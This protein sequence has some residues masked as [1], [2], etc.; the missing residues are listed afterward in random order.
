VRKLSVLP[1]QANRA[2]SGARLGLRRHPI[3][4]LGIGSQYASIVL[5]MLLRGMGAAGGPV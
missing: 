2:R 4:K 1:T 5:S 3:G